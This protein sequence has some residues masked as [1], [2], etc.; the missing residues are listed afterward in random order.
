MSVREVRR[1]ERGERFA[2][3]MV[4]VVRRL[5]FGLSRVVPPSLLGFAVINGFTFC[6]DMG[7]LTVMRSGLGWPL[8]V[9]IT[10]GYVI[11]FGLSF[12]LNRAFNFRSHADVGPQVGRYVVVVTVNYLAWILGVG[13]GL[14]ALGVDY[15][16]A[17]L[18]AGACEAVYMYVCMRWVVFRERA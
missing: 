5:P 4:A 11:A 2:A 10:I 16:L 12:V 13:S 9:S 8:P 7:L 15:H 18:A 3:V 17:R 14:A 1:A 6:V